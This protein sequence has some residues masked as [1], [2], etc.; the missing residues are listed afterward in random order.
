MHCSK[1]CLYWKHVL[2][3]NFY[4]LMNGIT[5]NCNFLYWNLIKMWYFSPS[6]SNF[7]S[8]T[9]YVLKK[10][11]WNVSQVCQISI[12]FLPG[13]K[14]I[15]RFK[16]ERELIPYLRLARVLDGLFTELICGYLYRKMLKKSKAKDS[17]KRHLWPVIVCKRGIIF[18]SLFLFFCIK[19]NIVS[20]DQKLLCYLI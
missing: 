13:L 8:F 4:F 19:C 16:V 14:K 9:A 18:I 7:I 15:I 20:T 6:D 1:T 3:G 2:N 11:S 12:V 5:H 10:K 17:F